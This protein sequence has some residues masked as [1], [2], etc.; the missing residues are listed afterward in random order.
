MIPAEILD[1][2]EQNPYEDLNKWKLFIDESSNQHGCGVDSV[3][4]TPSGD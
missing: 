2:E 4:Q 3:L 1:L